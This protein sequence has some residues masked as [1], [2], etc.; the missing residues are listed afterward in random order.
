MVLK[1]LVG[2]NDDGLVADD[3][4][5]EESLSVG[6]SLVLLLKVSALSIPVV[7][8]SLLG[9]SEVVSWTNDLLSDLTK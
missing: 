5:F 1:W 7:L 2:T 8:L 3:G 4:S 6:Q 9:L